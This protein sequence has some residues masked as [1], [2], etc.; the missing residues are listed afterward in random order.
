MVYTIF[1]PTARAMESVDHGIYALL[2]EKYVRD[3]MVDYKG[4]KRD[5]RLLDRYLA[6]LEKVTAARLKAVAARYFTLNNLTLAVQVP[7]GDAL[8]NEAVLAAI[9]KKQGADS[10]G[11][12]PLTGKVDTCEL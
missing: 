7:N 10:C 9:K 4:F 3:G 2:L 1:L 8:S 5:E 6:D 12:D 11:I